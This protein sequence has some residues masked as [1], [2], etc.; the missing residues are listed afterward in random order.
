MNY[1]MITVVTQK[2]QK[3]GLSGLVTLRNKFVLETDKAYRF[4]QAIKDGPTIVDIE[5]SD[6][7][8]ITDNIDLA[9]AAVGYSNLYD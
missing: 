7:F 1:R 6:S 2:K 8:T 5:I 9:K 4:V 3:L